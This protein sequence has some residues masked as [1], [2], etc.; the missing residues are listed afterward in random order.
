M[1]VNVY[2]LHAAIKVHYHKRLVDYC[3]VVFFHRLHS[4]VVE[5]H[6]TIVFFLGGGGGIV[7]PPWM[8]TNFLSII[9]V[10]SSPEIR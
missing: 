9:F 4:S 6:Y 3:V 2:R 1:R 8:E 5:H 10:I 7:N